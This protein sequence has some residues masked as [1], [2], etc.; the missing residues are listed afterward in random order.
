[1]S[2]RLSFFLHVKVLLYKIGLFI[3]SLKWRDA[4]ERIAGKYLQALQTEETL[5]KFNVF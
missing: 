4:I 2:V 5:K 3:A 1:M